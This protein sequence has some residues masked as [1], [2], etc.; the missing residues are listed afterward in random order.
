MQ[1]KDNISPRFWNVM[2]HLQMRLTQEA[3]LA[4][5][6]PYQWNPLEKK[7]EWLKQRQRISPS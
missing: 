2:K 3:Y 7:F 5:L 6:V 4:P 1:T